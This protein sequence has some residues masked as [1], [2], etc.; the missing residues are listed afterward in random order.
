MKH[1]FQLSLLL[2]AL[3]LP[4][5]ALAYDFEVDGI[6][7]NINGTEAT[8]TSC[9]YPNKYIGSVTI[10]DTVTFEGIT[11]SVTTIGNNAFY[12][13]SSLTSI[14]IP[15]SV[16]T[17]GDEAF[18]NCSGLTNVSFGSSIASIGIRAFEETPWYNNQP[19]GLVYAGFVAYK[20]KGIMPAGTNI[21]LA[22]GCLGI[23]AAAFSNCS[24]LTS[25]T[26]PNSVTSIGNVAF[27]GCSSLTSATI[28]NS[29]STFGFHVFYDCRSLKNAYLGNSI[30]KIEDGTFCLCSSLTSVSIPNSVTSIGEEAFSGC[31]RLTCVDIPDS[32]TS[33]GKFAF[34]DCSSLTGINIP[35][36]IITLSEAAF[37]NC[38]G[39]T[40]ITIPNSV[41]SIGN[42]TFFGCSGLTSITIPNSVT[43]IGNDAFSSCSDL[44]SVTIPNSVTTIGERAFYSCGG[45]TSIDIP[46]SVTSIGNSAFSYCSG[47]TSI[48]VSSGNP[49]YD[50]RNNC[51]AIIET[52]SNMLITGCHN[53][54][55]PNSVT[56]IGGGAFE[57]CSG[58]TSIT[59]PNSVTSIGNWA[60]NGCNNLVEI[61]SLALMPPTIDSNT[62]NGCYGAT[63]YVPKEAV[64][65]YRTANYWKKFTNI[66]GYVA[67]V[68]VFEVDGILYRAMNDG[69][70]T[71][72]ANEEM[73]NYYIGDKVIADTVTFEGNNYVVKIIE[74]N[75]FSDCYELT[76]ITI[77]NSVETIG[78]Q[79]FKGCTGLTSVTI[80]S[81]VTAIGAKAF[82]YCNA[83]VTVKCIGTV[84]PVMA[85]TDCFSTAAYNRAT[86]LVPRNT[87]ATYTAADYWYKFAHIDGWGSAGQGDVNGDGVMSILDVTSLIDVL[88]GN[89]LDSFYFDSADLN[90]NGRID[91]GDVTSLIDNLLNGDY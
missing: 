86:L 74:D 21:I 17:I 46:N 12:G 41:T 11:Y 70:A 26:I 2:L 4:A 16:T 43:S 25:I 47:L 5:T 45:L 58:L 29:V 19:D 61:Y 73:E 84:P 32:V 30:T 54:T 56:S 67:C 60:F 77:P 76:S 35:N 52:A 31:S 14:G 36:S 18:E 6:Y 78:E 81:G 10:P 22:E 8:V 38:A 79:A 40:S 91:I 44:T 42:Y 7:Y 39:L 64:N 69:T 75:A 57:S 72:I 62:F 66:V 68:G 28:P 80:G 23:A 33:I 34:S 37:A 50:S 13:C 1:L 87:E 24:G 63:L 82:N 15:N 48:V 53:T 49:T 20:Y 90:I 71:V 3:L 55:I 85:S 88:L 83:L 65:A 9:P 27:F 51:N 59:I 89:E